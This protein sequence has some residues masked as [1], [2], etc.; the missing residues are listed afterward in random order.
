MLQFYF[1]LLHSE[2][3]FYDIYWTASWASG[4]KLTTTSWMSCGKQIKY[5]FAL[6]KASIVFDSY[7]TDCAL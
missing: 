5:A 4:F 7:Q 6:E 2:L 1:I 3:K